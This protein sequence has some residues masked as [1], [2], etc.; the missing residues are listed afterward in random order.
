MSLFF[1]KFTRRVDVSATLVAASAVRV[2]V[3]RSGLDTTATDLPILR[4]AGGRPVIP[5]S[6]LKGVLRSGV[7]A[8]LRGFADDDDA[9]KRLACDPFDRPCLDLKDSKE[10]KP[11]DRAQARREAIERDACLA[12]RTFGSAGLASHVTFFDALV[13]PDS[14]VVELRDGVAIDRDL[15]RVSGSK[16]Y[17]FEVLAA[18]ARFPL[19]LR[20]DGTEAWQDGLVVLALELLHEGHLRVGG[21]TSRGLG[22]LEVEGRE[23]HTLDLAAVMAGSGAKRSEWEVFAKEGRDALLA[24]IDVVRT[25]KGAA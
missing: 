8:V 3:G 13:E 4:T 23:V 7:E 24:K 6:S 19:R 20:L 14:A 25:Q 21:A 12:C 10:G 18:G 5:G 2:G 9:A 11:V 16:K 1:D 22:R 17:D 15:G